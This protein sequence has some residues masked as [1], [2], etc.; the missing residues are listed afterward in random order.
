MS[1]F[2]AR[3]SLV[4]SYRNSSE[5]G[6]LIAAGPPFGYR[7]RPFSFCGR[8]PS[9]RSGSSCSYFE[10]FDERIA[11]Q[12]APSL[13]GISAWPITVVNRKVNQTSRS[14]GGR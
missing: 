11:R 12:R 5:L 8:R 10:G 9:I 14:E 4:F 7:Q 13:V 1:V 2:A 3:E 6:C